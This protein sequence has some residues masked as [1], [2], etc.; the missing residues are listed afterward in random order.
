MRLNHSPK[1]FGN[2]QKRRW[3]GE[4]YG[5]WLVATSK[6]NVECAQSPLKSVWLRGFG[7]KCRGWISSVLRLLSMSTSVFCPP[8]PVFSKDCSS[9]GGFSFPSSSKNKRHWTHIGSANQSPPSGYCGRLLLPLLLLLLLLWLLLLLLLLVVVVIEGGGGVV[10]ALR[11]WNTQTESAACLPNGIF[12]R[13]FP[14]G[15]A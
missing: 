2:Y 6:S 10:V 15:A 8:F 13:A 4:G 5:V 14:L 9:I 7:D 1:D 3:W 11:S 12:P